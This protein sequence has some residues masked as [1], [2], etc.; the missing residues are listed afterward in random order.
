MFKHL[1]R[2]KCDFDS[3]YFSIR[4]LLT[5][6]LI[7]IYSFLAKLIKF[8]SRSLYLLTTESFFYFF[9]D[10]PEI[11]FYFSSKIFP[12]YT[13]T[14]RLW[15]NFFRFC[16]IFG[17]HFLVVVLFWHFISKKSSLIPKHCLTFL[18]VFS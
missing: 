3:I 9:T 11:K 8:F 1:G 6:L 14:K 18:L 2:K 17:I 10:L 7:L 5:N 4:N 15:F 12:F 16:Y 13:E